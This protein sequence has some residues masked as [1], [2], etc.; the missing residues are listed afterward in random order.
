MHRKRYTIPA[1]APPT[2]DKLHLLQLILLLVRSF[3][4]QKNQQTQC[5]GILDL[6]LYFKDGCTETRTQDQ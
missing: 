6:V 4:K 5:F 2:D 1:P 3:L